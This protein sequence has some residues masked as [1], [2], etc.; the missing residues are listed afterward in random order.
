MVQIPPFPIS[1]LRSPL[2]KEEMASLMLPP[3]GVAL[4]RLGGTPGL[5]PFGVDG[6]ADDAAPSFL[7]LSAFTGDRP[8][9]WRPPGRT[10]PLRTKKENQN[11]DKK[12]CHEAI[13]VFMCITTRDTPHGRGGG[14]ALMYTACC[15]SSFVVIREQKQKCKQTSNTG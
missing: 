7:S 10:R 14:R 2:E 15:D 4:L 13:Y 6:V 8:S 11:Q 5:A 1:S 12:R 3:A 9:N